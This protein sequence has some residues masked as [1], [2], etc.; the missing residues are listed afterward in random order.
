MMMSNGW[1]DLEDLMPLILPHAIQ[2]T[3]GLAIERLRDAL[4]RAC[5]RARLWVVE[6]EF[7]SSCDTENIVIAPKEARIYQLDQVYADRAKL[8]PVSR[9]QAFADRARYT[10]S[11]TPKYYALADDRSL[12]IYPAEPGMCIRVRAYMIPDQSAMRAPKDV[13]DRHREMLANGALARILAVPA[14]PFTNFEAAN[15]RDMLFERRLDEIS[16]E[17]VTGA[18]RAPLRTR[19][20]FM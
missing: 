12:S 6:D 20:R 9:Q 1:R 7:K 17:F 16:R 19:A 5:E 4:V 14:Q 18:Q 15:Y 13:I 11:G 10:E 2:C 3:E 8:D